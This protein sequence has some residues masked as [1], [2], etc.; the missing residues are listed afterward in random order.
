MVC[1]AAF[2]VLLFLSAVSAKYRKLLK[3]GWYCVTRR[4]TFRPCDSTFREEVKTALLAPL[5]LKHPKAV[6]PASI[7]IEVSA[8]TMVLSLIISAYIVLHGGLNLIAFGTC[9]RQ[10]PEACSLAAEACGIPTET[11]NFW[12]SLT[13]GDIVGAVRNEGS[14]WADTFRAVPNRFRNWDATNYLPEFP[15]Y[16]GG[17][18]EGK[19]LALEVIDPGCGYCAQL[20]RNIAEADFT[21]THNVTYVV[22][23]IMRDGH[24]QFRNSELFA[25][26]LTAIKILEHDTDRASDPADWFLLDQLFD[27]ER[28]G[29]AGGQLWLNELASPD[30]VKDQIQQ[31]LT[32]HGY[33][34]EEIAAVVDK[35]SSPEVASAL[36]SNRDIVENS[37]R[38]VTIPTFIGGGDMRFG[39]VSVEDLRGM[40]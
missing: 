23:P 18:T 13:R 1:I 22:Y 34:A 35:T 28:I 36:A 30:E 9:N 39:A 6:K 26:Y 8:W 2:I 29:R 27:E 24:L 31:W 11:P 32:E 12:Q 7:A 38:T 15:S 3:R 37:I 5:A 4:V 25:Q 16:R 21:D 10:N 40:K 17:Y 19:P 14:A 20:S 33:S